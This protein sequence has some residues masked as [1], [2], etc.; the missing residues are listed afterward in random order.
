MLVGTKLDL[1]HARK[2]GRQVSYE[3]GME[4]VKRLNL[5]GFIETS[6]KFSQMIEDINDCFRILAK[7]Y[8]DKYLVGKDVN[9]LAAM[10]IA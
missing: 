10:Q 3:E 7:V 4:T 9:I 1:I 8:H 2:M 6:A 5:A